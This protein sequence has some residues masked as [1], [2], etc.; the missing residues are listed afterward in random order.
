MSATAISQHV[1]G[2]DGAGEA[3][4][5]FAR[6]VDTGRDMAAHTPSSVRDA[7]TLPADERH[8]MMD[9]VVLEHLWLAET[10]A[11]R[12]AYRGQDLDDLIQVARGGLIDAVRRYDPDHGDFL[13]F[14]VPTITGVLKRHFRDHAWSIRPPRETQ[15]LAL[16]VRRLWPSLVQQLGAE[17]TV[18]Q[19]AELLGAS[20]ASVRQAIR[21]AGCFRHTSLDAALETGL[22]F[23]APAGGDEIAACETRLLVQRMCSYLDADERALLWMRFY[24]ERSQSEIAAALG[25]NQMR[26]SRLL[27]RVMAK[28][29]DSIGDEFAITAG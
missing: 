7:A 24:E 17:P 13:P 15:E 27:S 4:N 9:D 22:S 6:T 18:D 12:F 29:R 3:E 19:L 28:L 23:A 16:Q 1:V 20:V 5:R 11:R 10:I 26:I 25:T 2:S 8:S 21:A 14:A